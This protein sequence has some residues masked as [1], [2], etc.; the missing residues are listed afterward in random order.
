MGLRVILFLDRVEDTVG[1]YSIDE[2]RSHGLYPP[3]SIY[4][5]G[6]ALAYAEV[7]YFQAPAMIDDGMDALS[8]YI[9]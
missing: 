8:G 9:E 6:K 1:F 4:P 3:G 5:K 7:I 2:N